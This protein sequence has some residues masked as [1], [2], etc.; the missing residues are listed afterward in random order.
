MIIANQNTTNINIPKLNRNCISCEDKYL[1]ILQNDYT[2]CIYLFIINDDCQN[3]I[4]FNF[5]IEFNDYLEEGTYT[6]HLIKYI[7]FIDF[8]QL[9]CIDSNYPELTEFVTNNNAIIVN[10]MYLIANNKLFT[11]SAIKSYISTNNN[12]LIVNGKTIISSDYNKE[13]DP[14][15]KILHEFTIINSGIL[16]YSYTNIVCDNCNSIEE[17]N[18]NINYISL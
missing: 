9:D 12:E 8:I 18:N 1:L 4:R 13:N 6:Y 11:T 2:K 15:N 10:G 17:Y 5:N 14:T 7:E 3:P 16:K